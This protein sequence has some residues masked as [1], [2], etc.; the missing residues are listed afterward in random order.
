MFALGIRYYRCCFSGIGGHKIEREQVV[1][2]ELAY[3][4]AGL[5]TS[6]FQGMRFHL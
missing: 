1:V 6:N 3:L 2:V 5:F 4:F